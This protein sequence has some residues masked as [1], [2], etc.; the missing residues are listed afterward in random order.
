MEDVAHYEDMSYDDMWDLMFPLHHP[1]ARADGQRPR[2]LPRLRRTQPD[3][4][5]GARSPWADP[6]GR[7]A[8]P[9]ATNSSPRTIFYAFYQSGIDPDTG[10]YD[11]ALADRSLL[12]NEECKAAG[13]MKTATV[14]T[15]IPTT[16][17]PSA[18]TTAPAT[19]AS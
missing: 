17:A 14:R 4:R 10:V 11:P 18:W 7:C 8:V 5:L 2:Q 12:Y 16:P 19:S 3:L 9:I 13:P 15:A 6:P 1:E